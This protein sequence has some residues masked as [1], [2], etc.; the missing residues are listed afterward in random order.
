MSLMVLSS[1]DGEK[2]QDGLEVHGLASL[3]ILALED[4]GRAQDDL[5]GWTYKLDDDS[6]RRLKSREV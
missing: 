4:G 6:F 1:K 3:M 2:A 5:G